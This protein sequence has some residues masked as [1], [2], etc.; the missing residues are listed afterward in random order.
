MTKAK[1]T[2]A[3]RAVTAGLEETAN[4][5]LAGKSV[6]WQK[7]VDE[8]VDGRRSM[9]EVTDGVEKIVADVIAHDVRVLKNLEDL[10][11]RY[12]R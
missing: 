4:D 6:N 10:S 2:L 3:A 1:T 7:L 11:Q 8:N 5:V 9:N 12:M